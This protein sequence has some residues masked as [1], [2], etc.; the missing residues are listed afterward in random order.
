MQLEERQEID[1]RGHKL[2]VSAGREVA[3]GVKHDHLVGLSQE[4]QLMR[5][6]HHGLVFKVSL[7]A[8]E[9]VTSQL[10]RST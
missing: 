1:T 7:D 2:I 9:D 5:D 4:L 8:P 10:P 6:Q 3:T